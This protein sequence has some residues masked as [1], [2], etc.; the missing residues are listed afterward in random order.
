MFRVVLQGWLEKAEV[1]LRRRLPEK[2]SLPRG[3][4][5]VLVSSI[6][7]SRRVATGP[8]RCRCFCWRWCSA[9]CTGRR[10]AFGLR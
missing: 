8:T 3:V 10:T 4:L 2:F 9:I 5:P 1:V 7:F 6:A